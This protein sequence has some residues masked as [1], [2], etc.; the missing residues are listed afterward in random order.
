MNPRVAKLLLSVA[1]AVPLLAGVPGCATT[2]EPAGVHDCLPG[3]DQ[4]AMEL[5][6]RLDQIT[7]GEGRGWARRVTEPAETYG[8]LLTLHNELA[9]ALDLSPT[10]D[11]REDPSTKAP[12]EIVDL[13]ST[14]LGI[15]EADQAGGAHVRPQDPG[16]L[17]RPK[18][19]AWDTASRLRRSIKDALDM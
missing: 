16:W 5:W 15:L 3:F 17:G 13:A 7:L 10:G 6:S 11:R 2:P 1:V 9:K 4:P 19:A 12:P 8:K 14:L 18:Y